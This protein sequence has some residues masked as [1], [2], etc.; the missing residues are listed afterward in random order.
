MDNKIIFS[1]YLGHQTKEVFNFLHKQNCYIQNNKLAKFLF[2]SNKIIFFCKKFAG[3][4]C[5]LLQT[6]GFHKLLLLIA[7]L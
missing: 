4:W 5:Y 7:R 6:P 1:N 3:I 2:N